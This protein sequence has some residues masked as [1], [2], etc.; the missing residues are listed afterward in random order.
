MHFTKILIANRGE[1]AVRIAR[2]C[3][4]LGI[5]SVAVYSEP[6]ASALHVRMADEA[7]LIGPAPSVQSYLNIEAIIAAA[8]KSGA[9]AIHP[10]Y[11]FLSE[12]AAFAQ[13]VHA[14]GLVLIGP[15]PAAMRAMGDKAAAR[16][17]MQAAG[18][19]VVPG[20]QGK[21]DDPTLV[22]MA[23]QIG[24]P[25]MI[26]AAAGGGGRGMRV[27]HQP[28]ELEE[29]LAAA[30][31]EAQHA[32]GDKRL[33]LEK[34]I[35]HAHHV[36]FQ[37]L[38][39]T[40]GHL[41][42][43]FERECSVQRRHQKIIEESP[44]PVLDPDLRQR[45]GAVAVQAAQSVGY[46]NAGTIEFI[47]DPR[48]REFYFLEMNTRLQVEHPVTEMVT[49]IDLV[50]WQI[51]IAAGE[52]FPY[53]QEQLNQ[54]G[55]AIECRL[56]A[57]DPANA[58]LPASGPLL[59]FVQPHGPGIRVDAGFSSGDEISIHYDPLLA[60]LIVY[61]EARSSA[62]RRMQTALRQSAV[63]G[64]TT[65]WQFLQDILDNAVFAAGQVYTTWVDET[66][67]EWQ[68]PQC[69]VPLEVLIAAALTHS[70]SALAESIA[71]SPPGGVARDAYSPWRTPNNFRLGE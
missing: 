9:Q 35:P 26:K 44:S 39:D 25:M 6:D 62:I 45:M 59:R 17:R 20:Y 18:V 40:Q 57:E 4:E 10:G 58:F 60:K 19:P 38:G 3:R 66:F 70:R 67:R 5:R 64:V 49:G 13:A 43:L 24:Y 37:V 16:A 33:I 46:Q 61:G 11:G 23:M 22:R 54:R 27:V 47:L 29:N 63:L 21:D 28:D 51:R 41:V 8:H 50:H 55:H 68:P 69:R 14:A 36:E 2:A 65:N 1:I 71:E 32:F 42:H 12:N 7:L 34:Y 31:R 53:A 48:T 56:Y 52:P 30:R 15:P